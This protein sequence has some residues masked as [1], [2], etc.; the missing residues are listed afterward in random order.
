V[1]ASPNSQSS[2]RPSVTTVVASSMATRMKFH[3][4]VLIA[5]RRSP[6]AASQTCT[7]RWRGE[8]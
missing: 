1:S 7:V 4:P 5:A 8:T 2:A 6:V 3:S